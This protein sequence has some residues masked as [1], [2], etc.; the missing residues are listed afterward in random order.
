MRR[1]GTDFLPRRVTEYGAR[2]WG[3]QVHGTQT[4]WDVEVYHD[5]RGFFWVIRQDPAHDRKH[6]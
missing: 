1:K 4:D 3:R 5:E 6:V 2:V